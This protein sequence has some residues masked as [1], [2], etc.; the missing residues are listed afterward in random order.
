YG[1]AGFIS[2]FALFA[3]LPSCAG[4][5]YS[6]TAIP[7]KI[8]EQLVD[9]NNDGFT[10]RVY[11]GNPPSYNWKFDLC[12][13]LNEGNKFG[14]ETTIYKF[15][16]YPHFWH[17]SNFDSNPAKDLLFCAAVLG[18]P[19]KLVIALNMGKE[20]EL[21]KFANKPLSIMAGDINGD[22]N[23]DIVFID[24]KENLYTLL[25]NGKGGFSKPKFVERINAVNYVQ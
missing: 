1:A 4:T 17:I 10:D 21:M 7:I 24:Y 12:A 6:R 2:L 15:P 9:L 5:K 22:G 16:S 25:G 3:F 13:K 19:Y 18:A 23:S 8:Y 20:K 11:V 14:N